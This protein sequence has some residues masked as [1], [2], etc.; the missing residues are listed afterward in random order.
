M[1]QNHPRFREYA[2]DQC[3]A[4]EFRN[5]PLRLVLFKKEEKLRSHAVKHVTNS[6]QNFGDQSKIQET[7]QKL[8]ALGC[9]FFSEFRPDS[10]TCGSCRLFAPCGEIVPEIV[11]IYLNAVESTI[12]EARTLPRY[13]LFNS[14]D[15]N[16]RHIRFLSDQRF[17]AMAQKM[18][19]TSE[20][21]LFTCYQKS[22]FQLSQLIPHL[23]RKISEE[24]GNPA[25]NI[26]CDH[27]NWN[28]PE[29][30]AADKPGKKRKKKKK[31]YKKKGGGGNF[32]H[33]LDDFDE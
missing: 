2:L 12:E 4:P 20:F 33:Y 8:E 5:E 31:P 23:R 28:P 27:G 16:N 22:N 7:I 6:Y 9:P 10:P 17:V 14:M 26:W 25:E 19:N 13:V 30:S 3:S 18:S 32:R 24:F 1:C 21:N 15:S 11:D 29:P